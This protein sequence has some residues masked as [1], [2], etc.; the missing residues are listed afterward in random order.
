MKELSYLNKYLLKY[1]R[2]LI[3]GLVFVVISNV[4]PD[5]PGATCTLFDRLVVDDIQV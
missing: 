5:I 1:K 4:L 3:L 2:H